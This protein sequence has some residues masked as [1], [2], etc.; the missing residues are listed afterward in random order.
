[1]LIVLNHSCVWFMERTQSKAL[2]GNQ[3]PYN[4][5]SLFTHRALFSPTYC[6]G[7]TLISADMNIRKQGFNVRNVC[8]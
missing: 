2:F 3:G 8:T 1:M 5:L 6:K 7:W 4:T